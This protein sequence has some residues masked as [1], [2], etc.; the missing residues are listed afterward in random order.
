MASGAF[1]MLMWFGL[2][3]HGI[4]STMLHTHLCHYLLNACQAH[5]RKD[6]VFSPLMLSEASQRNR[7]NCYI[8]AQ[9]N[10][11]WRAEKAKGRSHCRRKLPHKA[12]NQG[13]E[14]GFWEPARLVEVPRCC[15]PDLQEEGISQVELVPWQLWGGWGGRALPSSPPRQ[16]CWF[17]ACGAKV[18]TGCEMPLRSHTSTNQKQDR[19]ECNSSAPLHCHC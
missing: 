2:S 14:P 7:K 12:C 17:W 19:K 6:S 13:Q 4:T 10:G 11:P 16:W 18:G 5:V 8:R 1:N 9:L 15:G 3:L